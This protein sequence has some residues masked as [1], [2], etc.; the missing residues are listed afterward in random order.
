MENKEFG[1]KLEIRT[2]E[3]A[4]NIIRLSSSLPNTAENKI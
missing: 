1:K 2:K 4:I 3:F